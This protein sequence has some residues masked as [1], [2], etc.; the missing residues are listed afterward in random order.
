MKENHD[1]LSTR[2]ENEPIDSAL[3]D[4]VLFEALECEP[5]PKLKSV[6]GI[7]FFSPSELKDM[8]CL[9]DILKDGVKIALSEESDYEWRTNY[10][11]H[12]ES[13]SVDVDKLVIDPL[14]NHMARGRRVVKCTPVNWSV[15][16]NDCMICLDIDAASFNGQTNEIPSII[17][18][19][20]PLYQWLGTF[21]DSSDDEP[22]LVH[23]RN[24][25][26]VESRLHR[27]ESFMRGRK[28]CVVLSGLK[29]DTGWRNYLPQHYIPKYFV[30]GIS[31][32]E[33]SKW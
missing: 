21:G 17:A 8:E 12:C 27:F 25:H 29:C 14:I 6:D 26:L 31:D 3:L 32:P 11:V 1:D 7:A 13:L 10:T 22:C 9:K 28:R 30:F 5:V 2:A 16:A 20:K 19:N 4:S 23:I 18:E 24:V 33:Q 15:P